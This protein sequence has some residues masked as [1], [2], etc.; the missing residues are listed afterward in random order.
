MQIEMVQRCDF[1]IILGQDFDSYS[2]ALDVLSYE[3]F[4]DRKVKLCNNII[5]YFPLSYQ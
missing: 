4:E 5:H 3:N 1:S 2:N